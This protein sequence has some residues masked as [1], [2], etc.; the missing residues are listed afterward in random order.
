ME[1]LCLQSLLLLE[2]LPSILK[3]FTDG[4]LPDIYIYIYR[5]NSGTVYKFAFKVTYSFSYITIKFS[6]RGKYEKEN[7]YNL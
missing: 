7:K 3:E 5:Q 6:K 4:L 1:K 2:N